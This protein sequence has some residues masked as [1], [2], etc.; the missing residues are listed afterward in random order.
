MQINSC[1]RDVQSSIEQ[2]MEGILSAD[3]TRDFFLIANEVARCIL[4]HGVNLQQIET[5][6]REKNCFTYLIARK[7]DSSHGD[8]L[9][10]QLQD[11]IKTYFLFFSTRPKEIAMIELLEESSS[12]EE[13]FEKL[14]DTGFLRSKKNKPLSKQF[15]SGQLT[16]APKESE[17]HYLS[18]LN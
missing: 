14:K 16:L 7:R 17:K 15:N 1:S 18:Q 13:N 9:S 4:T 5:V 2:K 10:I 11:V 3:R 6:L 8:D 12:Y